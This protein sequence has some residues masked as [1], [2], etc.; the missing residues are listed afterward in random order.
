[1][2]TIG[3][4]GPHPFRPILHVGGTTP[5]PA[6]EARFLALAPSARIQTSTRIAA[7]YWRGPES[8]A[9]PQGPFTREDFDE[10][11]FAPLVESVGAYLIA[12]YGSMPVTD[13]PQQRGVESLLAAGGS[14]GPGATVGLVPLG[15]VEMVFRARGAKYFGESPGSVIAEVGVVA[16]ARYAKLDP[17]TAFARAALDFLEPFLGDNE[18]QHIVALRL[19]GEM[20]PYAFAKT[21]IRFIAMIV[22]SLAH[23]ASSVRLKAIGL[24]GD[25]LEHA[26]PVALRAHLPQLLALHTDRDGLVRQAAT[27]MTVHIAD[28]RTGAVSH[29]TLQA[30]IRLAGVVDPQVHEQIMCGLPKVLAQLSARRIGKMTDAFIDLLSTDRPQE[31]VRWTHLVAAAQ[32]PILEMADPAKRYLTVL[33]DQLHAESPEVRQQAIRMTSSILS[34]QSGAIESTA[35]LPFIGLLQDADE[36]VR[37]MAGR[38]IN[39]LI[40]RVAD[41]DRGGMGR[42]DIRKALFKVFDF[43][44]TDIAARIERLELLAIAAP[45][46][47]REVVR[48][49][50]Q[51]PHGH[52]WFMGRMRTGDLPAMVRAIATPTALRTLAVTVLNDPDTPADELSW[53]VD[54]LAFSFGGRLS[55]GGIRLLILIG[56]RWIDG[57]E[58]GFLAFLGGQAPSKEDNDLPV[59]PLGTFLLALASL[60]ERRAELLRGYPT[61]GGKVRGINDQIGREN[62]YPLSGELVRGEGA[63]ITFWPVRGP[64]QL[65]STI[66]EMVRR[67]VARDTA[68][69]YAVSVAISGKIDDDIKP[70]GIAIHALAPIPFHFP[71]EMYSPAGIRGIAPVVE[72]GLGGPVGFVRVDHFGHEEEKGPSS[73]WYG[74]TAPRYDHLFLRFPRPPQLRDLDDPDSP[75]GDQ[76]VKFQESAALTVL[77]HPERIDGMMERVLTV[78]LT[79]ATGLDAQQMEAVWL[80]PSNDWK[81]I[82]RSIASTEEGEVE[83]MPAWERVVGI[84]T[85]ELEKRLFIYLMR[86]GTYQQ[87][88]KVVEAAWVLGVLREVERNGDAVIPAAKGFTTR[89]RDALRALAIDFREGMSTWLAAKGLEGLLDTPWV[90]NN[91]WPAIHKDMTGLQTALAADPQWKSALQQFIDAVVA[92]TYDV[93]EIGD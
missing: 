20:L 17:A 80:P 37:K 77:H 4:A 38:A 72:G 51:G 84:N 14:D 52:H 11:F 7:A 29:D 15:S 47:L 26:P 64:Y 73:G 91:D 82:V 6:F 25:L 50:T 75:W 44:E 18:R 46:I 8:A 89:K 81:A 74:R 10:P 36:N 62:G 12:G 9:L 2:M 40:E 59:G 76:F 54:A 79:M 1:M 48:G 19:I 3:K 39:M 67:D 85:E 27:F 13:P 61:L 55:Y 68:D 83:G 30:L 88:H 71:K 53:W 49:L 41:D 63:P 90:D 16:Q 78:G 87:L 56:R 43:S 93:L 42:T 70:A 45:M 31:G 92:Q 58:D 33:V 60:M 35:L 5:H 86:S 66:W 32:A 57:E 65:I 28:V 34:Q 24:V 23:R 69:P 22:A 21:P